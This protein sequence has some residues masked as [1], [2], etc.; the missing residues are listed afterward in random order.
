MTDDEARKLIERY[1]LSKGKPS[2]S[3]YM[4]YMFARRQISDYLT[5]GQ[6]GFLDAA[7]KPKVG[8]D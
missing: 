1:H 8:H 5:A 6:R 7:S 2:P 4:A 3:E